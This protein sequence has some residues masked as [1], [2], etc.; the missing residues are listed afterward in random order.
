MLLFI[1]FVLFVDLLLLSFPFLERKNFV[2][3]QAIYMSTFKLKN[4]CFHTNLM[5][6]I[7]IRIWPA[8]F[9]QLCWIRGSHVFFY[10]K[11]RQS[12]KSFPGHSVSQKC[13]N[14]FKCGET[15]LGLG[16]CHWRCDQNAQEFQCFCEHIV[17]I[18]SVYKCEKCGCTST[19]T[20]VWIAINQQ[21]LNVET[22]FTSCTFL[23]TPPDAPLITLAP[24]NVCAISLPLS[25]SLSE[26]TTCNCS[27]STL[28][29]ESAFV[30]PSI[31]LKPKKLL[32]HSV[33]GI[34]IMEH[35][36]LRWDLLDLCF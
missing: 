27:I 30:W 14:S 18:I 5:K 32:L 12:I 2:Y 21:E 35:Y 24:S 25:N 23:R 29:I 31:V 20:E 16:S 10:W 19:R 9:P 4:L 13:L 7:C 11:H 3:L 8:V 22:W 36:E 15:S 6:F 17:Q 1:L 26:Q 34:N 28:E 33:S